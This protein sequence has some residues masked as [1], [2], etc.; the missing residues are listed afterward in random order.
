MSLR[1]KALI[2]LASISI[3][4]LSYWYPLQ[5]KN[6]SVPVASD[7]LLSDLD[8]STLCLSDFRGKIVLIDFM[9][10]RCNQCK[11]QMPNL[12]AVWEVYED[13][14]ILISIDVDPRESENILR[15][16]TQRFPYARWFWAKDTANL[17]VKYDVTAIPKMVII[18]QKGYIRYSHIGVTTASE[19][20]EEIKQLSKPEE[21]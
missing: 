7:F 6:S 16:F 4:T 10:T 21:D 3:L 19:L 9:A 17:I 14:I 2:L 20:I 18:D 11:K 15:N 5:L 1:H 12:A 13:K 8:G